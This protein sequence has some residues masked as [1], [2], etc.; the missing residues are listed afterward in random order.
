MKTHLLALALTLLTVIA[1][2]NATLIV[3]GRS[4]GQTRLGPNGTV[5]LSQLPKPDASDYGMMQGQMVWVSKKSGHPTQTLLIHTVSNSVFDNVRPR[6]GVTIEVI[7]VTSPFFH[8]RTGLHT[9]STRTQ[10]LHQYPHA[11]RQVASAIYDDSALGI[12]FEFP[13]HTTAHSHC[14]AIMVHPRRDSHTADAR[15]VA[16]TLANGNQ[17]R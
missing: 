6:N 12:A 15:E 7:R 1:Q 10:I 13:P 5:T 9:G 3:P 2:A 11:R 14:I 16:E 4:I 17:G 8:T